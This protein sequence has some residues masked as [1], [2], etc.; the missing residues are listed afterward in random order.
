MKYHAAVTLCASFNGAT[1]YDTTEFHLEFPA[2]VTERELFT[3]AW[4]TAFALM[5]KRFSIYPLDIGVTS[6]IMCRIFPELPEG[7]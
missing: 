3:T 5:K 1:L 6:V 4:D 7:N 2:A